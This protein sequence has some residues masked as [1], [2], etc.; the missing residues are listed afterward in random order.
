M[1]QRIQC[2]TCGK[3]SYAGC[4]AHIEQVLG[5]VPSDERCRCRETAA[6]HAGAK[7]ASWLER[8]LGR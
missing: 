6:K 7:P 8:V 2:K 3:P 4:G 5:D 1:C